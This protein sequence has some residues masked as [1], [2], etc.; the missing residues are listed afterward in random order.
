MRLSFNAYIFFLLFP[1]L[2]SCRQPHSSTNDINLNLNNI[3]QDKIDLS[4]FVDSISFIDL[5]LPEGE[6]LGSIHAV[7]MDHSHIL[8]MD[9]NSSS[10][11]ALFDINGHFISR[12]GNRGQGPE[13]V[14]DF[15]SVDLL[16]DT[17]YIYDLPS[18]SVKKYD[19]SGKFIG[20]DKIGYGYDFALINS[21][22]RIKYLLA[23]YRTN[24][25]DNYGIFLIDPSSQTSSKL[26]S[27]RNKDVDNCHI[28]EFAFI[29]D[30]IN[31]FTNDYEYELLSLSNDTLKTIY[32]FNV[33]PIPSDNEIKHWEM[34]WDNVEKHFQ[35]TAFYGSNRWLIIHFF[36]KDNVR[37]VLFDKNSDSWYIGTDFN[38][39]LIPDL[40][41]NFQTQSIGDILI[42]VTCPSDENAT[43]KIALAHLKK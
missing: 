2:I 36:K 7:K 10:R 29:D 16:N 32:K 43:Q 19:L 31:V 37:I 18:A 11:V 22:N 1:L 20:V 39:D 26:L 12:I 3:T 41:I 30:T 17:V 8:I 35:R 6:T 9:N 23:N 27:L 33:S 38:N 15:T 42:G 5:E 40:P 21:D 24:N 28:N 25:P 4:S 13:E 34:G 14:I